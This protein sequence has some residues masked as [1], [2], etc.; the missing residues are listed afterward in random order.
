MCE[1]SDSKICNSITLQHSYLII[2]GLS[3]TKTCGT[4]GYSG[5][6]QWLRSIFNLGWKS[7]LASC[8]HTSTQRWTCDV[9]LQF[10]QELVQWIMQKYAYGGNWLS[11]VTIFISHKRAGLM[12]RSM[13]VTAYCVPCIP[14]CCQGQRLILDMEFLSNLFGGYSCSGSG[15]LH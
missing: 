3:A 15:T 4:T 13:E 9:I 12:P 11:Y 7:K 14:W 2:F 1:L 6:K 8:T 5:F 10:V